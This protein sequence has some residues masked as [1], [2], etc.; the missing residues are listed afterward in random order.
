[1]DSL[2]REEGAIPGPIENSTENLRPLVVVENKQ[3]PEATLH[4]CWSSQPTGGRFSGYSLKVVRASPRP[5]HEDRAP[6]DNPRR[7]RKELDPRR[8]RRR[9]EALLLLFNEYPANTPSGCPATRGHCQQTAA[10][11]PTEENTRDLSATLQQLERLNYPRQKV[12]A[13][14][15]DNIHVGNKHRRNG[16]RAGGG[17]PNIHPFGG[18]PKPSPRTTQSRCP[19]DHA[20]YKANPELGASKYQ[21]SPRPSTHP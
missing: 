2:S 6:V 20:I 7:L 14:A 17:V 8:D 3:P 1:M 16:G 11:A 19:A 13:Q 4:L 15:K 9:L 5:R 18:G 21:T 12:P 10:L